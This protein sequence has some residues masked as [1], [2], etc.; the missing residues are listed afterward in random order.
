MS[1]SVSLPCSLSLRILLLIL[2]PR[3]RFCRLRQPVLQH[4]CCSLKVMHQQDFQTYSSLRQ[5]PRMRFC[6]LR[7]PVLQHRCCSLKVL[8]QQ[9]FQTYTLCRVFCGTRGRNARMGFLPDRDIGAGG[10]NV[11]FKVTHRCHF[12][13]YSRQIALHGQPCIAS[14]TP[15]ASK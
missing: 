4:R 9:D 1:A 3:M 13:T 12:K 10:T 11:S 2:I 8:H 7:Q 6:R 5:N 15:D 14:S